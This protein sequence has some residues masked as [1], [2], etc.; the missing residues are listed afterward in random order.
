MDIDLESVGAG[1]GAGPKRRRALLA[2]AGGAA[3]GS[4]GAGA[5]AGGVN[6]AEVL[7]NSSL[8]SDRRFGYTNRDRDTCLKMLVRFGAVDSPTEDVSKAC[9]QLLAAMSGI[10]GLRNATSQMTKPDRSSVIAYITNLLRYLSLP[11]HMHHPALSSFFM[12]NDNLH[13]KRYGRKP[14]AKSETK[15]E[16]SAAASG[17]SSASASTAVKAEGTNGGDSSSEKKSGDAA[18][19]SAAASTTTTTKPVPPGYRPLDTYTS[20][21][22]ALPP[23]PTTILSTSPAAQDPHDRTTRLCLFA[24]PV[25]DPKTAE[26]VLEALMR[27]CA[28]VAP[29]VFWPPV[30]SS[31]M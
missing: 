12:P 28:A 20:V 21:W 17:S 25:L 10:S 1:G 19:D 14:T 2:A 8:W 18:T 27:A 6:V 15:S 24:R 5:G 3:S 4:A 16:A 13:K 31:C 23:A 29:E 22:R 30:D 9:T 7:S 11:L 26:Q